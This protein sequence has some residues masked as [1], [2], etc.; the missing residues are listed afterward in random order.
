MEN[1][2]EKHKEVLQNAVKAIKKRTFFSH[3]P[4]QP[5]PQIYGEHA[6]QEGRE[7][8]EQLLGTNFNEILQEKA[9]K[10]IGEEESPFTQKPLGIKYPTYP[11]EEYVAKA[12]EAF[13]V[14]RKT[15]VDERAGILMESLEQIRNRFFEIAYA[16]MHTTGQSFMMAFQASGPHAADRAL[17]A[18][19]AGYG[20]LSKFSGKTIWEKPMGKYNI[21][22]EKE[23]RAVPKGISLAIGCSTFPTWNTVPGMYAS[24]ITGNPVIVKPHPG[25]VLPM[26]IYISEIQKILKK[27]GFDPHICQLAIDKK[28]SPISKALAAFPEIKLIDYTGNTEFG[29]YLEQ[30]PGKITFTEKTG[31]NSIILDS[32]D[33]L[34]KVL[35]NLAV[36]VS[37]Y[38]GQMCTA[39]QNI[40]I[41][42]DGIKTNEGKLGFDA[43]AKKFTEA[44]EGLIGNPKAGPHI[45]G[46]IQNENTLQRIVSAK[47][48]SN[49]VWLESKSIENPL[50]K[51]ARTAAPLI[52]ELDANEKEAFGEEHFG[53]IILLIK[54]ENT[55]E[56]IQLAQEL[57]ISKGAISC[58][59]YTIDPAVKEQ[60]ADSMSL[61]ATPVSFNLIG[62]I[63]VNQNASFSDFHVT[64][65]NPSGNASFTDA[66]YIVKRFNWVGI[67]EPVS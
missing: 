31:V 32:V 63:Y 49:K 30:L 65:G 17:E 3:F 25:S 33:D 15:S 10:W 40:F 37:L 23:W 22:L 34:D 7:N 67:R 60:I 50:F 6:D 35:Q 38:S 59:A 27:W 45:L 43:V 41:P 56:S 14:W 13:Q 5:L 20:E 12:K 62:G 28:N 52:L 48:L 47:K 64:G 39:P 54:T 24:L 18:V 61:A 2:F 66:E 8:F 11:L 51:E 16:T 44:V 46:G 26:A 42:K 1:L 57:A 4:E 36:S 29:N 19:A 53:P 21:T 58:G 9:E 55:Q